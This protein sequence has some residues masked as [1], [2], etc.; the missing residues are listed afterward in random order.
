MI[1]LWKL[2]YP[3]TEKFNF[4]FP[5]C[6]T[7]ISLLYMHEL[8]IKETNKFIEP[9][10]EQDTNLNNRVRKMI[11]IWLLFWSNIILEEVINMSRT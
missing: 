4:C 6:M 1:S 8:L 7:F 10:N 9:W 2:S 3:Q 5:T 11:N